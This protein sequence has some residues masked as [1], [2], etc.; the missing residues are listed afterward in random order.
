MVDDE[1]FLRAICDNPDDD[2]PRLIYADWLDEH[3][4]SRRAEFIRLQCASAR[5][6]GLDGRPAT[7]RQLLTMIGRQRRL[8]Q[9]YEETWSK[10]LSGSGIASVAYYRGFVEQADLAWHMWPLQQLFE[11]EPIRRVSF[12]TL[13]D[14]AALIDCE[15]L[16][17]VREMEVCHPLGDAGANT[18]AAA[19]DLRNLKKLGVRGL[20]DAGVIALARSPYLRNL[21][22]LVIKQSLIGVEAARALASMPNLVEM[23][24][25]AELGAASQAVLT[26][27]GRRRQAI[28]EMPVFA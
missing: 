26:G 21:T 22:T 18:L 5:G 9:R 17:N 16:V 15:Q 10:Y 3:G 20:G 24:W 12:R 25:D 2:L 8:L 4:D 6:Q 1:A 7:N 14:V 13:D 11:R 23:E 27:R 28:H 19:W